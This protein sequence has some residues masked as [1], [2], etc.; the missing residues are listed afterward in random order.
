MM[1]LY[2]SRDNDNNIAIYVILPYHNDNVA[3]H[4]HYHCPHYDNVC[5]IIAISS[6]YI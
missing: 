3:I 1:M 2:R 6:N 5:I 4:D